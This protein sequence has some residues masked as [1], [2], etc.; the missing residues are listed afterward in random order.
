MTSRPL[1]IEDT[2]GTH[3]YKVTGSSLDIDRAIK[4]WMYTQKLKLTP[5]M[6]VGVANVN[7]GFSI[8]P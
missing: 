6:I 8:P 2:V 5:D 4:E 7:T 1:K 3:R